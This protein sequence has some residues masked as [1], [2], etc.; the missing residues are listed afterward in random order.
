MAVIGDLAMDLLSLTEHGLS[1]LSAR[2]SLS[3]DQLAAE[4]TLALST[5]LS[6]WPDELDHHSAALTV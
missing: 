2:L 6:R 1:S 3:F 4:R 5:K